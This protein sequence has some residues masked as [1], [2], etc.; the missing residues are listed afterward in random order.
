[1]NKNQYGFK[2]GS[3]TEAAVLN[4]TNK[5]QEALKNDEHAI[6]IFLDIQGAFDNLPHCAISKALNTTAAKGMVADWIM[7]MI[8][9]RQIILKTSGKS[10]TRKITKGCPQGGVLSPFLWNLVL[11]NL[12]QHCHKDDNVQAFADDINFLSIGKTKYGIINKAKNTMK[13]ILDWCKKMNYKSVQ[14]KQK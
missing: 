6:G 1:M 3:S 2:K 4:L 5:I 7:H 12:L 11:D 9:N 14:S 10:I 8:K 13:M